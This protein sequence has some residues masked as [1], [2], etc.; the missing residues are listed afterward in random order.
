MNNDTEKFSL[1]IKVQEQDIDEQGRAN[2]V[3]Y[4]RWVQEVAI[5][6]WNYAAPANLKEIYTWVVIRH[7][8][9]YFY[10]ALLGDDLIGYTWVGEH[11]GAKFDR[12]V[13][14]CHA[15]SGKVLA[16]AKTTWCLLDA[17]T[18]RPRRIEQDVLGIL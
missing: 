18:M 17:K 15:G 11:Q 14:L 4:L 9:D 13:K 1:A 10:P 5:A 8:I 2:N 6:H 7:E 16:E 3:V 12:F